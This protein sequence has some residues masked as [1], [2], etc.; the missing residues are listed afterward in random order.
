MALLA[1]VLTPLL[2]LWFA[3]EYL[4]VDGGPV[5]LDRAGRP[6]AG[7][8]GPGAAARRPSAGLATVHHSP[9]AALLAAVSSVRHDVSGPLLAGWWAQ[10][11]PA[12]PPGRDEAPARGR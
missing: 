8:A 2:V 11:D 10:R 12:A 4:P 6:G 1:P 7:R 3:G 9:A 5:H